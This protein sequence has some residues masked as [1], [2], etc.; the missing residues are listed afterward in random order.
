VN[1]DTELDPIRVRCGGISFI[2]SALP[3]SGT[4]QCINHTGKFDQQTI[5]GRFDDAP[6]ILG[7]GRVYC[8]G[9][10]RS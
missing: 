5:T 9:S 2:H 4:A 6:S 10:D 8:F 3:F 7:D 1:T